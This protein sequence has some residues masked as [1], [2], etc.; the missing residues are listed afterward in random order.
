VEIDPSFVP[1]LHASDNVELDMAKDL[2]ESAEIPF[3][4]DA[5]D[6]LEMLEVLEGDSAEG[7]QTIY[8]PAEELDKA[9]SL[10]QD[11][12]GPEVFASKRAKPTE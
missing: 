10:L 1:L 2:L 5:S 9:S 12:W 11:A 7:L 4:V 8:V 3:V 6:R